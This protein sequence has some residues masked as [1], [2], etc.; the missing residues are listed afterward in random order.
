MTP[1]LGEHLK[2]CSG[3]EN[4]LLIERELDRTVER[5]PVYHA[6]DHVWDRIAQ[7][8]GQEKQTAE[9]KISVIEKLKRLFGGFL[10]VRIPLRPVIAIIAFSCR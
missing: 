8:I 6:P 10:P 9:D 5:L 2:E 1:E 4:E 3:C 7:E